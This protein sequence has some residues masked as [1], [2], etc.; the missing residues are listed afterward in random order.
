M[1]FKPWW[2]LTDIEKSKRSFS[3]APFCLLIIFVPFLPERNEWF[4]VAFV[5]IAVLAFI[6][7]GFRYKSRHESGQE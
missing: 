5:A 2:K 1:N 4:K 3:L 7:Q 6:L